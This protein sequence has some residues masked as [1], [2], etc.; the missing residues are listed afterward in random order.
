MKS[1]D[2]KSSTYIDSSKEINE[3]NP[4]FKIGDT[5]RISK[6]KTL[7]LIKTLCRGNMLLVIL[8]ARKLLKRF[9]K[10]IARNKSKR[11]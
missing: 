9:R 8:K 7:C 6:Y 4:K 1:V 11:V 2:V 10:R 3:K 5:V